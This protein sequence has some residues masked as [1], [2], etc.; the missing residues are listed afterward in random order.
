MNLRG[1]LIGLNVAVAR[2]QQGM[3]MG[4]S[5]PVKQVS[6]ALSHFFTP[7][8][9][10]GCWFGAQFAAGPG[11]LAVNSLEPNSPAARAGL[12]EGDVVLEVNGRAATSLIHGSHL[13]GQ[14]GI[15]DVRLLVARA[16]D[17]RMITVHARPLDDLIRQRLGLKLVEVKGALAQRLGMRE[18][19][20]L[21]VEEVD[22]DSPAGQVHLQKGFFVA[23][24][25]G[26]PT[27][28][29]RA[30]AEA[31]AGKQPGDTV[32]MR[33]L[34]RRALGNGYVESRDAAVQLE[35]R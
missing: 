15:G 7:E 9:M 14:A 2:E 32:D 10:S 30:A 35:L 31:L 33:V 16:N 24:I 5:I 28:A 18:G 23:K 17:C 26:Q 8:W 21:L 12:R 6:A 13:L 22:H 11:P 4:F 27:G 34:I 25:D 19:E 20:S 1:E 3:G 29:L